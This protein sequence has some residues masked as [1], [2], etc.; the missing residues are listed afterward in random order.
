MAFP[1][2]SRT[3]TG[4]N[5]RFTPVLKV[6]VESCVVISAEFCAGGG[7]VWAWRPAEAKTPAPHKRKGA[8]LR[9]RRSLLSTF[10]ILLLFEFFI[11]LTSF[12]GGRIFTEFPE[13]AA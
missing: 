2:P 13:R 9:N 8:R 3:T 4:T 1:L 5:T 11:R 12:V 7:G 6:G 10:K